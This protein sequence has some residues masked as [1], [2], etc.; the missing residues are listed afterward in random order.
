[1]TETD[2]ASN[3]SPKGFPWWRV[4]GIALLTAVLTTAAT[5]WL[6]KTYI[7][8]SPFTPVTLSA[9]EQQV[10]DTKLQRLNVVGAQQP[11]P[12]AEVNLSTSGNAES[13]QALEPEP[14]REEP[15]SRQIVLSER[16]LNALLANNTDLARKLAI[17]LSSDLVSAKLLVPVDED[18]PVLGGQTIRVKAGMALSYAN[19]R[20]LVILQGISIMGVPLPN[21]W[22][23]GLKHVDLVKQYEGDKGFWQA[24]MNGVSD[25]RVQEGELT[26]KLNE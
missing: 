3:S 7:F 9:K 11:E 18:F 22:L 1:M 8:P 15:G 6:I 17:D 24:F 19:G 13:V 21:A 16:E 4:L 26:I 12:A 25:L 14:Y 10:L 2:I 20:P 5:V 23:G